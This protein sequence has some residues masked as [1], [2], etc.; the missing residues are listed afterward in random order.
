MDRRKGSGMSPFEPVKI[1]PLIKD[2]LKTMI[3]IDEKFLG[4]NEKDYSFIS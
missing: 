2:D 4:E 1:R 3:A